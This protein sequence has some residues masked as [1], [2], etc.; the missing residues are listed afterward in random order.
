MKNNLQDN[1]DVKI[2]SNDRQQNIIDL[3]QRYA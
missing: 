1:F 3:S 2:E